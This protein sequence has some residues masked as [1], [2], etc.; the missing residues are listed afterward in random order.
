MTNQEPKY[1]CGPDFFDR[2]VRITFFIYPVHPIDP[3]KVLRAGDRGIDL[4]QPVNLEKAY[5]LMFAKLG[6][7]KEK[8]EMKSRKNLCGLP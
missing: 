7:R 5:D 6:S 3:V 1:E 2:I 4:N 8:S